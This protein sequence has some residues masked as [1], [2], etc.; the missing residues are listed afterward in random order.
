MM[1]IM[2]ITTKLVKIDIIT[3]L[4]EAEKKKNIQKQKLMEIR[5]KY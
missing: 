3:E 2:K 1:V 4:Q 5:K